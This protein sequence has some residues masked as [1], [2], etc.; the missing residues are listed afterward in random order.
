[1]KTVKPRFFD[2][3][4]C[5]AGSCSDNCCIGWEID[6]DDETLLKY[7][8]LNSPFANEL[9]KSYTVSPDGSTLYSRTTP[10]RQLPDDS[11]T[12]RYSIRPIDDD[13]E[14]ATQPPAVLCLSARRKRMR[15]R[16]LLRGS[17]QAASRKRA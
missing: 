4:K 14:T 1:M 9:N 7:K 12:A 6:I 10:A 11:K 16:A 13:T 3:F 8:S 2:S 5:T 15:A 17:V